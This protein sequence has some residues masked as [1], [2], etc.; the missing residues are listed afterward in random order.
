MMMS[1]EK[2]PDLYLKL[3][4]DLDF[5]YLPRKN[6][7]ENKIVTIIN[8]SVSNDSIPSSS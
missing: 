2:N 7:D 5:Y 3:S 4:P 8:K 1:E 6:R